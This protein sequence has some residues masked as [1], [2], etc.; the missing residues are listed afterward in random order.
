MWKA[1]CVVICPAERKLWIKEKTRKESIKSDA[2]LNVCSVHLFLI[3][4]GNI[5][6]TFHVFYALLLEFESN[7]NWMAN[8]HNTH[9]SVVNEYEKNID[10]L[11]ESIQQQ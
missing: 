10:L 3:S 4:H 8:V 2:K 6:T 9:L 5:T 11:S 7:L 1:L